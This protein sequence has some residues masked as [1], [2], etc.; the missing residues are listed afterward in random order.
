MIELLNDIRKRQVKILNKLHEIDHKL[1]GIDAKIDS[2]IEM[3]NMNHKQITQKLD[4]ITDELHRIE[5][6]IILAIEKSHS[7]T[8]KEFQ[9]S[10]AFF[11]DD[12]RV[13]LDL[14]ETWDRSHLDEKISQCKHYKDQYDRTSNLRFYDDYNWCMDGVRTQFSMIQESLSDLY[15]KAK[16]RFGTNTYIQYS[17]INTLSTTQLFSD[18]DEAVETRIGLLP[19]MFTWLNNQY[20]IYITYGNEKIE[21]LWENGKNQ[22]EK[23]KNSV[24]RLKTLK[25]KQPVFYDEVLSVYAPLTEQLPRPDYLSF[26][27]EPEITDY[28]DNHLV[29]M[30]QNLRHIEDLSFYNREHLE[31]AWWVYLYFSD[32]M[33]RGLNKFFEDKL[34]RLIK[35]YNEQKSIFDSSSVQQNCNCSSV[36]A[37]TDKAFIDNMSIQKQT[38]IFKYI[39]NQQYDIYN[40][41]ELNPEEIAQK[42]ARRSHIT[43]Q[44]LINEGFYKTAQGPCL[45]FPKPGDDSDSPKKVPYTEAELD[46]EEQKNHL[47][48]TQRKLQREKKCRIIDKE[49][50]MKG[51]NKGSQFQI[52]R[53]APFKNV[54]GKTEYELEHACLL[55]KRKLDGKGA[56]AIIGAVVGGALGLVVDILTGGVTGGAATAG[57][58]AGGGLLGAHIDG[59]ESAFSLCEIA[60]LRSSFGEN[61][62][63][64]IPAGGGLLSRLY[65]KKKP[66]TSYLQKTWVTRQRIGTTPQI[67]NLETPDSIMMPNLASTTKIETYQELDYAYHFICKKQACLKFSTKKIADKKE[68]IQTAANQ[69]RQTQGYLNN[70]LENWFKDKSLIQDGPKLYALLSKSAF[71]L[72]TMARAGYGQNL[73]NQPDLLDIIDGELMNVQQNINVLN[74]EKILEF[75]KNLRKLPDDKEQD[76]PILPIQP[77]AKNI[78]VGLGKTADRY[79]ALN[80]IL[81]RNYLSPKECR[82][83]KKERQQ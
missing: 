8:A 25:I 17:D 10:G 49:G 30:C 16:H 56:G 58:A 70:Q 7:T 20:S 34:M 69:I 26:I 71:T 80:I 77:T 68:W 59:T 39:E 19:S 15:Q 43:N 27:T 6:E 73:E 50:V 40:F 45:R 5:N 42:A 55:V 29:E 79:T 54:I 60:E 78:P 74:K 51:L 61:N 66:L 72:D 31:K 11:T 76:I 37:Q 44:Y 38:D 53:Y 62:P 82:D 46:I 9:N 35:S 3:L 67:L 81:N 13:V 12:G 63:D 2:I 57:G 64:T 47:E 23:H 22:W 32:Q 48:A 75:I 24:S 4:H 36:H 21:K 28:N 65:Y 83:L 14:F 41:L 1:E 33:K 18:W 52:E